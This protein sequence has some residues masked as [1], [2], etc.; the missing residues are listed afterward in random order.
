M[1]PAPGGWATDAVSAPARELLHAWPDD[2]AA[3]GRALRLCRVTDSAVVL[4]SA[5]SRQVLDEHAVRERGVD[6]LRRRSG[7][8]AVLLE[9]GEQIWID[10]WLPRHDRLWDD[11]V[12]SSSWWLGDTW[13][14]ALQSAGADGL[15]VHRGRASVDERS[16]LVCFAGVGP[17][18]VTTGECKVVGLSQRRTR[19]GALFSMMLLR[20]WQPTSLATLLSEPAR[21]VAGD[22]QALACGVDQLL[23]RSVDRLRDVE[24]AFA[25]ALA[26]GE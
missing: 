9:P 11:D 13:V 8:G 14:R 7:G 2:S 6:V 15:T 21:A 12:V 3:S 1:T 18:E 4:G 20:Q 17:G 10:L 24:E 16:R 26:D 5:Q 22:M 25:A 23:D 19:R